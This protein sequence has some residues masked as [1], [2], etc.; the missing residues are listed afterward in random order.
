MRGSMML[1]CGMILGPD[2]CFL[3]GS[4]ER[5]VRMEW[6]MIDQMMLCNPLCGVVG[7]WMMIQRLVPIDEG[8]RW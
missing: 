6:M 2:V 1:G 4:I 8:V 7:F 5:T 3:M